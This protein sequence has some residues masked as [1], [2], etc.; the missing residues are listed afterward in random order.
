MPLQAV[1]NTQTQD[2]AQVQQL[3]DLLKGVMSDQQVTLKMTGAAPLVLNR[4]DVAAANLLLLAAQRQGGSKW[5]LAH[6][7][8]D[9]FALL[10]AAAN[11]VNFGVTDLGA[12]AFRAG[13]SIAGPLSGVTSLGMGGALSGVTSLAMSGALSGATTGAFSGDLTP[14]ARLILSAATAKILLGSSGGGFRDSADTIDLLKL[15]A[16][17]VATL[18][19]ALFSPSSVGGTPTAGQFG[20]Q[21]VLFDRQVLG[22]ATGTVRIPA[23]GSFP[24]T[25]FSNLKI[26][27]IVV[28]TD[29]ALQY[30]NC[31]VDGDTVVTNYYVHEFRAVASNS[32]TSTDD[33]LGTLAQLY[34]GLVGRSGAANP[35]VNIIDVPFFQNTTF[36]KSFVARASSISSGSAGVNEQRM[37]GAV[38]TS[39]AALSNLVFKS[40]AGNFAI[41]TAFLT[42][43]EP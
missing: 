31:Q 7:A 15:D 40:G 9:Q 8:S 16:V 22:S 21:P 19:N 38:H 4:N 28:G 11:A 14:A 35:C 13:L 34:L 27:A 39:T 33:N 42:Y 41:G 30:L 1:S 25:G 37:F 20:T 17:G 10:N 12:G 6:D 3:I 2:A 29:A 23:S 18:R 24:T 5:F 36:N 26:K 43:L 32:F